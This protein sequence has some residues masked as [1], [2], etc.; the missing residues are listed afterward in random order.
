MLDKII[1]LSAIVV[2][3]AF[4]GIL[5]GFVPDIDL[6]LVIAIVVAM[7]GYDFYISLF[8]KRNG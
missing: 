4:M 2:L 6:V 3:I 7:A 5:I 8:K 1:G